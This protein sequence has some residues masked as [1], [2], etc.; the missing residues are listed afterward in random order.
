MSGEGEELLK[1][2]L[3]H[4]DLIRLAEILAALKDIWLWLHMPGE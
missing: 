4:Y 2:F 3:E 1:E